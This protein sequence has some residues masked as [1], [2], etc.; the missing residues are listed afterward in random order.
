MCRNRSSIS[1]GFPS[2]L[3]NE[4]TRTR[5]SDEKSNKSDDPATAA[6]RASS[7]AEAALS[8]D[9]T[10]GVGGISQPFGKSDGYNVRNVLLE[11][12]CCSVLRALTGPM[13]AK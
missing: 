3:Q 7:F 6:A 10:Q 4:V 8:G 5:I 1:N 2:S 12:P 13:P 9:M 11:P